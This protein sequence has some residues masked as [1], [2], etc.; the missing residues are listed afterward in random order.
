[1]TA[2]ARLRAAF[3]HH[4]LEGWP[5]AHDGNGTSLGMITLRPHQHDAIARCMALIA[6]HGGALLAD[7]VGLG[8]TFVALAI[9]RAMGGAI[10]IA[11][12]AL[13]TEWARAAA[14]AGMAPLPFVSFDALSR[15][16]D[17]RD[18][19]PLVIV[20]EAHHAR[21]PSTRRHR[22]LAVQGERRGVLLLSATPVHNARRDLAQLLSLVMGERAHR[23]SLEEL[24]GLV[25]RRT[26]AQLLA[27]PPRPAVL[28]EPVLALP[29]GDDVLDA[30]TQLAPPVPP[31]DGGHADA[32][33]TLG[34]VRAWAS[35]DAALVSALQRRLAMASALVDALNE[36]RYPTRA[37]LAAWTFADGAQQL[38]LPLLVSA[39]PS[40][41][42]EQTALLAQVGAHADGVRDLLARLRAEP[43]TRD[44]ARADHLRTLLAASAVE[45]VLAFTHSADTARA[46]F[47]LLR[48]V[49][50]V[51]V[52]T[53]DGAEVAG[54]RLA[55]DE[56]LARFAPHARAV[57]APSTRDDIRLL[58][59]TDLLSEG[60]NLQDATTVVHLDLPW[61]PAR[62]E[63]RV[64]RVVRPGSRATSVRVV[65]IS[66]P[67]SSEALLRVERRLRA[68][69]ADASEAIGPLPLGLTAPGDGAPPAPSAVEAREQVRVVLERWTMES[70][71]RSTGPSLLS[72]LDDVWVASV[73]ELDG[74]AR[75][76][77]VANVGQVP[78][79][80]PRAVLQALDQLHAASTLRVNDD[81]AQD[82]LA[83]WLRYRGAARLAGLT[84]HSSPPSREQR[85]ALTRMSAAI[86]AAPPHERAQ[87]AELAAR[88]RGVLEHPP[89]ARRDATLRALASAH[90]HD[91]DHWLSALASL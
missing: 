31:R 15:G 89:T 29:D 67:A 30:I 82:A 14:Q 33:V 46:L 80:E 48:H 55:R 10:V 54:G 27:P 90:P 77:L 5:Y 85:R 20:D 78:T 91:D 51:A 36:A 52:L 79:D 58:I 76:S 62:L 16:V 13:R 4:A 75:H 45:R 39:A 6:R 28:R 41:Q 56:T 61:T 34:L 73:S 74:S 70:N 72:T 69:L 44:A 42:S 59:A 11:P 35:S 24:Q 12:A 1:M 47:R 71:A 57:H 53:A 22:A 83:R 38:A 43:S 86:T 2:A 23:A 60:L 25:V 21:T 50:Q 18:D 63:Q 68:K 32:L 19:A 8:K 87:R 66:P 64:G 17:P 37:E 49:P 26:D 65:A 81:R 9:A 7:Q 3:A 40:P 88:A 84:H